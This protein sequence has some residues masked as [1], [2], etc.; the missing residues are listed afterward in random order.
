MKDL[1]RIRIAILKELKNLHRFVDHME[2]NV[3]SRH[4]LSIKRAYIFLSVLTYHME[5]GDLSPD[6]IMY[7]MELASAFQALDEL[8]D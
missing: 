6:N 5:E 4:E 1:A 7:N 2:R 8:N 3:K